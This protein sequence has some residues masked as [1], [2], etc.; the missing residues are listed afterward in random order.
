LVSFINEN[1]A[2]DEFVTM[3]TPVNYALAPIRDPSPFS[4]SAYN[5][6]RELERS[7]TR[8]EGVNRELLRNHGPSR[9]ADLVK[10][11]IHQSMRIHG[12]TH[13]DFIGIIS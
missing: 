1:E 7:W 6:F 13:L 12:N 2:W 3:S 5:T 11:S 10:V 8:D 4:S 9:C